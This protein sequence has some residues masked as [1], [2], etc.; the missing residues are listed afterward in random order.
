MA[1]FI[2]LLPKFKHFIL[3]LESVCFCCSVPKW[4]VCNYAE[5][6]NIPS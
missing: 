1:I 6:R 2:A 4:A 5:L 3:A